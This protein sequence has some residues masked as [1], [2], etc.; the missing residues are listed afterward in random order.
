MLMINDEDIVKIMKQSKYFIKIY[1]EKDIIEDEEYSQ[2]SVDSGSQ[3]SFGISQE[4]NNNNKDSNMVSRIDHN[5]LGKDKFGKGKEV[6]SYYLN[7]KLKL[8]S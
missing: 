7:I 8:V 2:F 1:I 6:Y 5:L 4:E 3:A